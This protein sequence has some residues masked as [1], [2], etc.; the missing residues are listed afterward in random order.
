MSKARKLVR[1]EKKRRFLVQL[2]EMMSAVIPFFG[3][4]ASVRGM[5]D[6]VGR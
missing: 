3:S 1:L 5:G 2:A 4:F 6:A